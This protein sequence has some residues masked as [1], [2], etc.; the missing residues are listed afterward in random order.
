MKAQL[1][2]NFEMDAALH[3]ER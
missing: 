1:T 3:R 2:N